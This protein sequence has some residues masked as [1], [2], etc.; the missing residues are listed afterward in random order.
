VS[1]RDRRGYR[2]E[3]NWN[4]RDPWWTERRLITGNWVLNDRDNDWDFFNN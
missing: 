2:S 3:P 1:R 4:W